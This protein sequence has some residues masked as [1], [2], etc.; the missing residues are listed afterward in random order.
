MNLPA[1]FLADLPAEAL[2][3]ASLIN[4]A[5]LT[6]RRN[7]QR[8]LVHRSTQQVIHL[9]I[10]LSVEWRKPAFPFR[11]MALQQAGATGFSQATLGAGLDAF[12]SQITAENLQ[13]LIEQDL[14]NADCL[15]RFVAIP[16]DSRSWRHARATGPELLVH[17]ASGNLPNPALLS[18]VLGM[19]VRS[20]Q[21]VKCA[22]GAALLPRLFAHSLYEADSRFGACLEVAEWKGADKE[23]G[24]ALCSNADCITATGGDESV[25]AIRSLVPEGV[26]FVGYGHRVSFGYIT[27]ET[28]THGQAPKIAARAAVDIAA[29]NQLGCLSPHLLF[30][31]SGGSVSPDAL[32]GMLADQLAAIESDEPRGPVP[33]ETA[34]VISTR[35]AFYE[36]R[37][38]ASDDTRLWKSNGSTAWTVVFETE[39]AFQKSCLNRFVYVKPVAD[40]SEALRASEPVRGQISTVGLEANSDRAQSIAMEF[41][42]WGVTR[43][44]PLGK[45]Q[46]PPLN[47]RHDGRP[48]LG[49][50][51]MWTDWEQ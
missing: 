28:L 13:A 49:D 47:W 35:R 1:Y 38:A 51:V 46:Q 22:S 15:D 23:L 18:I 10:S 11:Q 21:F 12:F 44:C 34:S 30:V 16:P 50:L 29:W 2:L 3:N 37:A 32:A 17:V 19:L 40:L 27:R 42:A 31:E 4:E 43:I 41:A 6:L 8:Y 24:P 26:R 36:I 25:S 33:V 45:M 9:L 48:V 14:G 5:C 20:A 7:R 39:T